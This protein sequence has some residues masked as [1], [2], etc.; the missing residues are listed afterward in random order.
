MTKHLE[1]LLADSDRGVTAQL[2]NFFAA[3]QD[4][5]NNP[6]SIPERQAVLGE[7]NALVRQIREVD[8]ALETLNS[9]IND[10]LQGLQLEVNSLAEGLARINGEIEAARAG[11][12]T[13]TQ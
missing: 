3:I 13:T 7:A 2:S 10:Q 4:L 5:S 6:S 1:D 11:R 8:N 12:G 9:R